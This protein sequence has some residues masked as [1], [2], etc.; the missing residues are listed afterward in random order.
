[1]ILSSDTAIL[2]SQTNIGP[3]GSLTALNGAQLGNATTLDTTKVLTA[4]GSATINAN[5]INNGVVNGPTGSG[6]EL[7]FT[8]AVKGAGSTTGNVEYAASYSPGN[9]TA[10][11][12][13]QNLLLDPTSTLFMELARA[14]PGNDYDQL[15]ISG[16]ATFN[17]RLELTLLNGYIPPAGK[18][19]DLFIGPT[20]G[21][22]SQIDL[23]ALGNGL[24][25]NTSNLDTNGTI[26]V[27]PEPSTLAL[28]G[29]AAVAL[30]GWAWR[31]RRRKRYADSRNDGTPLTLWFPSSGACAAALAR[32]E[33]SRRPRM[34]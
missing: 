12:L 15:S 17:G 18:S 29:A 31:K 1:M 2:G 30:A 33:R 27:T 19:F 25:W 7:T 23:P 24:Q 34:W 13:I 21:S 6:Q 5:F 14:Q 28:F 26:S 3:G 10:A 16:L 11:V 20:T 4:T 9:S 22:F 8:Q 32:R